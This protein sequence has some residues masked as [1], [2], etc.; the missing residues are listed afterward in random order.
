MAQSDKKLKLPAWQVNVIKATIAV[1]NLDIND[2]NNWE[3]I[4]SGLKSNPFTQS[5]PNKEKSFVV[6]SSE[7][8]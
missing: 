4:A 3:R 2:K 8:Y 7:E 1:N 5:N 6:P